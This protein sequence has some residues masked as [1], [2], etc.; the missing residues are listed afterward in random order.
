M[1]L[2]V[3]RDTT[4]S[5]CTLGKLY[6]DN[7]YFCETLEDPDRGLEKGGKK[8]KGQTA[9]PVGTYKVQINMSPRFNK[10]MPQIMNVPQFEGIRIHPGNTAKDTEGCLLVGYVRS[11]NKILTSRDAYETLFNKLSKATR[12]KEEITVEYFTKY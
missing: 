9:I 11:G 10:L 4:N 12:N 7:Q 1:K 2:T 5:E 3:I 6:I 8:I